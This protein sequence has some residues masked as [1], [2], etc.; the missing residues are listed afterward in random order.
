MEFKKAQTNRV[1]YNFETKTLLHV[2]PTDSPSAGPMF[3]DTTI[4][5]DES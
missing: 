2:Y 4:H 5:I 1:E 3:D